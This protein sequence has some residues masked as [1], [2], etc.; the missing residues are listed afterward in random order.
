MVLVGGAAGAS[1]GRSYGQPKEVARTPLPPRRPRT[2]H[3]SWQSAVRSDSSGG[4]ALRS[5][6]RGCVL[7]TELLDRDLAHLV[8][9][10]LAG[11]R[12]RE[13]VDKLDVLR[14]LEMCH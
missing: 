11:D 14:D 10:E 2:P 1:G 13:L 4:R 12:H 9:L 6:G 7:E 5:P 8:L 3:R